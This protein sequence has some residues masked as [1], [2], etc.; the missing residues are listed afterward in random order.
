M[1]CRKQPAQRITCY[2]FREVFSAAVTDTSLC[3][4]RNTKRIELSH[5]SADA[6]EEY[7]NAM[8]DWHDSYSQTD[9]DVSSA[10]DLL[11]VMKQSVAIADKP[12]SKKSR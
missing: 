2:H 4:Q 11:T 9:N 12:Q 10:D 3:G 5:Y 7:C 1:V 8:Q 6:T